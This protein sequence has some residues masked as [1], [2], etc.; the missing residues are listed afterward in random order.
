MAGSRT[1]RSN[2]SRGRGDSSSR[3]G[4][5]SDGGEST[6]SSRGRRVII[7]PLSTIGDRGKPSK[8]V[9][10]DLQRV[11]NLIQDERHLVAYDLYLDCK[12]RMKDLRD[13][14][15]QLDDENAA[16]DAKSKTKR[17]WLPQKKK[18]PN[19]TVFDTEEF[20][21]AID[22]VRKHKEAFTV[23]EVSFCCCQEYS[24]SMCLLAN[25]TILNYIFRNEPCFSRHVETTW[26]KAKDGH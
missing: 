13:K 22:L 4:R 5:S 25:L 14:K 17:T 16:R 12:E 19:S 1:L 18:S 20:D 15:K 2:R 7:K 3:G 10:K 21:A 11:V 26:T 8:S 24:R 23:L 9:A 6:T